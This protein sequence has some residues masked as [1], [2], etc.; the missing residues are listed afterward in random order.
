[1]HLIPPILRPPSEAGSILLQVTT[2]CSHN[3]CS[4]CGMYKEKPF[5]I[6]CDEAVQRAIAHAAGEHSDVNRAFLLDGDALII[7]QPRLMEI[8]H[9]IARGLPW[10]RRVACYAS[11]KSIAAKSDEEL[12]Q[13]RGAGLTLVHMGLESGDDETLRHVHKY[14]DSAFIVAQG[15]RAQAAGLKLFVTVILGLGGVARSEVHARETA[16]ALSAL[17][18]RYVGALSLMLVDNTELYRQC[19]DGTFELPDARGLL[20]EL[21]EL[22]GRLDVSACLFFSNH[23]SNH[24]SLQVR[25]PSQRDAAVRMVDEALNGARALRAE[26]MRGL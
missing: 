26:W 2:G 8:L 16:R 12:A 25:L 3:R 6:R 19:R 17:D 5:T 10:V 21:R 15:K 14:G 13:L 1:M 22:V 18:P 23:A 9:R 20:G 24:L 11:A 4:F 7:A